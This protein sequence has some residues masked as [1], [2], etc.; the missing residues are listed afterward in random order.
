MVRFGFIFGMLF[1]CMVPVL[2]QDSLN[3]TM[4]GRVDYTRG[5]MAMV[6]ASTV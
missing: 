3:V 4:V 5:V 6:L 2:A 1:L